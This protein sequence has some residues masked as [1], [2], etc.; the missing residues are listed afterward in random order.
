MGPE[1]AFAIQTILKIYF[2][3]AWK[4]IEGKS[5]EEILALARELKKETDDLQERQEQD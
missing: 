1:L 4:K 5:Q 2:N 3:K